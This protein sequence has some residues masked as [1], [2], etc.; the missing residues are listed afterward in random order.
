MLD[1]AGEAGI[2]IR[3]GVNAGSLDDA[4]A[5]REDLSQPEKL[6][7]SAVDYARYCESRGFR[8]LVVSA[9]AHDVM[10]TVR[11]CPKTP[12]VLA[13]ERNVHLGG[14]LQR[15]GSIGDHQQNARAERQQRRSNQRR[16]F[17][18]QR[19]KREPKR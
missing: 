18:Q 9:K 16:P 7:L 17:R 13:V 1:A 10:T 5:A 8:D 3:I 15:P 12:N 4:I 19:D 14:A 11:T 2:P 6:A